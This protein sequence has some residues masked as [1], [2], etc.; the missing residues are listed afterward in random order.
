MSRDDWLGDSWSEAAREYRRD[1]E[2]G[3][4]APRANGSDDRADA[5]IAR[6]A[7]L[8][9]VDYEHARHAA[10]ERL[11]VRA[12]ILDR[13]VAVER[14]RLAPAADHMQGRALSLPHPE[15]WPEPVE[16][17]TLLDALT[18][19]IRRYVVMSEHSAR[20]TAL[21]AVHTYLLDALHISPRLAV[22]SPEK[23]CGKTTLFDVLEHLVMRGLRTDNA[24]A[25]AI[26]RVVETAQPTLLIDEADTFLS[27]RE[28]LR[29]ILNSG[30]RRGGAV[31]RT[32]GDDHVPRQF[33]TYGACAIA[34]IGRLP[35]TLADRS[36]PIALQRR[37]IDEPIELFRADRVSH[38]DELARRAARWAVDHAADIHAADPTMPAG[39]FNRAADNW[40]GLLAIADAS[41]GDWP[42]R[43]REACAALAGAVEDD[44]SASVLL[45]GDIRDV[46]AGR[47]ID[48]IASADLVEAVVAIEGRP[49]G[50]WRNGRPLTATGLARLL[51]S[52]GIAP[53]NM[54]TT[55]GAGAVLKGYMRER[56]GEVWDRYLS[57]GPPTQP[58]HRYIADSIGISAPAATATRSD[59]VAVQDARK[60]KRDGHCSG[61]A[62]VGRDSAAHCD[63]C[64][65]L[66]TTAD[67]LNRWDWPGRP[68]GIWLHSRCED[69]WFDAE[70]GAP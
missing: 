59:D 51:R 70:R 17:A 44:Q 25:A 49:W 7:R 34:M 15:P 57:G 13:L 9:V 12:S 54:R 10:A 46:F 55:G 48:R 38:L 2:R 42:P 3:G 31:L 53:E 69:P 18:A 23:Q 8:S 16:G 37:R 52:F 40:R 4:T 39:L 65:A 43:A 1:R 33:A 30:H 32:V 45:L 56:F 41:G 35:G 66:A 58:L 27:L 60:P 5:E 20:A 61:V 64:G 67:S 28:E 24:T 68:D 19:A 11:G 21:W 47:E 36:I 29:G 22:T 14:E 62:A 63:H 50:E 6:L 26:F